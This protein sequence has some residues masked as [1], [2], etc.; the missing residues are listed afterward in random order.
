[1][2]AC[3]RLRHYHWQWEVIWLIVAL[4]VAARHV[5][6]EQY[7]IGAK[8]KR[9]SYQAGWSSVMVELCLALSPEKVSNRRHESHY[10]GHANLLELQICSDTDILLVLHDCQ[11]T[12][13][14]CTPAHLRTLPPGQAHTE[15]ELQQSSIRADEAVPPQ[16]LAGTCWHRLVPS[17]ASAGITM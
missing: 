6:D 9:T 13:L 3:H 17:R 15:V 5:A 8:V 12:T 10:F 14:H 1:M 7:F 2:I 16:D 11:S 4:H